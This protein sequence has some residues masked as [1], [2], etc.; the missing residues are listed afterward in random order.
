MA[1]SRSSTGR[2]A[3]GSSRMIDG[4]AVAA[5]QGTC[6]PRPTRTWSR[7]PRHCRPRSR[8]GRRRIHRQ[9]PLS[10]HP[11]RNAVGSIPGGRRPRTRRAARRHAAHHLLLH[12]RLRVIGRLWCAPEVLTCGPHMTCCLL[13]PPVPRAC[14]GRG[15]PWSVVRLSARRQKRPLPRARVPLFHTAHRRFTGKLSSFFAKLP[16][17]SQ[18]VDDLISCLLSITSF[19]SGVGV[20]ALPVDTTNS[21]T[22]PVSVCA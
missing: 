14:A 10:Q 22:F 16:K 9:R 15:S 6:G 4:P 13:R 7:S 18:N 2:V 11:H 19:I 17:L 1:R 12:L 3:A 8:K 21:C 5:R 20:D